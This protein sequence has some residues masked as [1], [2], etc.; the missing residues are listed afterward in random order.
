MLT[1]E[2]W[3]TF[4]S[5]GYVHLPGI[6]GERGADLEAFVWDRL[7]E[8]H[9]I[10]RHD[11]TT[12]GLPGPWVGMKHFKDA[13]LLQSFTTPD[14]CAAIDDLL[15]AGNWKNPRHWGGFL[16][17]LPTPEE[18]DEP[19]YIP[20]RGWHVDYHY[21][22]DPEQLFGLRVFS[23]LSEVELHGGGTLVISGSH[24]VVAEYVETLSAKE[25][26]S[27]YA[28]VRDRMPAS[29]PWFKSLTQGNER[30]PDR[31]STFMENSGRVG[32]VEVRVE[33]LCGKPGDVILMH[34]WMVHCTSPI[35]GNNP[36]FM[37]A[38][39][40]YAESVAAAA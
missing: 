26:A 8:L 25:R 13:A 31:I 33:Q 5:R 17:N 4:F 28:K 29:L 12:W 18:Q 24:R 30:D 39:N 32:D 14:L 37:L 2:Q 19:W 36:R 6:A 38:K 34:P 1:P 10:R 22:H 35:R 20:T 27:G 23:F 9:G 21:T 40:L 3:Q 11:H 7:E 15:G 16:V